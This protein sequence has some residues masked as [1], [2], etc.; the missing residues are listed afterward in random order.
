MRDNPFRRALS[1]RRHDDRGFVAGAEI[2][3]FGVFA[4]VMGSLLVVNVWN[5]IDASL[6][7][8][9]A[10]REGVRTFQEGVPETA[11]EESRARVIEVLSDYDR[12]DRAHSPIID[13][14]G[15]E[16]CGLV[17]VTTQYDVALIRLPL[18]GQFGTMT[19]VSSTHSGVIDGYRS[20]NFGGTCQ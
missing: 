9:A 11:W 8:S 18:F 20:G 4:F 7:V 3:I 12:T 10:S 19:E 2:L 17:T 14:D 6:A 5:V 1:E 13:A 16:R 15:F